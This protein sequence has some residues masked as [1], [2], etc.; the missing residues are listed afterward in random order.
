MKK[1]LVLILAICMIATIVACA[2]DT[3]APAAP[4]ADAPAADAPAADAPVADA[5][6]ADAPAGVEGTSFAQILKNTGNPYNERQDAGFIAAIEEA[7]GI[8]IVRA[9]EQPTAE[10]QIQIIDELVAQ[11]VAA[12]AVAANDFDALEPAAR[13]A[14]EAGVKMFSV[15]S[16]MNPASRLTFVNQ[17]GV[18]EVAQAL[19]DAVLDLAGGEGEWA[20]LSATSQAANQ[21]AW[22]DAIQEIMDN[23]P[24]YANLDLVRI[25]YGDDLRD[26]SVAETE[27]LIQSFPDLKVIMAP[28]TVGI[29]AA[30]RVI[31]DRGLI[32]QIE[33]TGLGLPSEMAEYI[34]NGAC[35][36][37]FLWNP[38]DVG[39][40]A[41]KVAIALFEG[42]ITGAAG[43]TFD[44]GR[45]GE[46]TITAA[47]DGGTEVILGP[48]FRFDPSNIADWK[49]V[50]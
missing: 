45:L 49:D 12:I 48:P 41:G 50:Y 29:A 16:A 27:A 24:K 37:M 11:N 3:P 8:A 46:K 9:P 30:G 4:A 17:A 5:P 35:A 44:A 2:Q 21:N 31:T 38:I 14:T 36:Y 33:V 32:G 26:V 7:G 47:D 10:G 42:K 6:A 1:L 34:D 23:D 19:A 22:I 39:Y 20:I 18:V 43:E 28:T 40:L 25:A 15:D 13:R